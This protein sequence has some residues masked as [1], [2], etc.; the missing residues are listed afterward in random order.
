MKKNKRG[1]NQ[2]TWK[3]IEFK[4]S[5][6]GKYPQILK[7]WD[8]KKNKLNPELVYPNTNKKAH[9]I[10]KRTDNHKWIR[11]ICDESYSYHRFSK[12]GPTCPHCKIKNIKYEDS[13]EYN[14][15]VLSKEFDLKKN[16][17]LKPED[18]SLSSRLSLWWIC[19]R[20][21]LHKFKNSTGNRI[22]FSQN[23]PR[24]GGRQ[25][26]KFQIIVYT[27]LKSIFKKI[28]LADKSTNYELD[29]YEQDFNFAVEIDSLRY[30]QDKVSL[31]KKK[32]EFYRNQNINIFRIREKGLKKISVSDI[33]YKDPIIRHDEVYQKKLINNLLKNI[34]ETISSKNIK[35]KIQKYIIKK[36]LQNKK[37]FLKINDSIP[38]PLKGNSLKEKF[39][40]V[41]KE[42]H[43]T[44]NG[45]L[46]PDMISRASDNKVWWLCKKNKKH[47]W[48]QTPKHRTSNKAGCP[49]CSRQ[50]A[51]A[52]NNIKKLYPE[53][54]KQ[55]HIKLNKDLD[56]AKL[57]DGSKFDA[58]WICTENSKHVFKRQVRVYIKKTRKCPICNP[59]AG[60]YKSIF[61]IL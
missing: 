59:S 8:Y 42:F 21:N 43:P 7:F 29:I 25:L 60:T 40:E 52:D 48:K 13:L 47:I 16:F 5:L 35:T 38:G 17:P 34:K 15:P 22:R 32:N 24:C 19:K 41:A 27:E 51:D 10:C 54:A 56:V 9:W 55:F 12:L 57:L 33:E 26:S 45:S 39:P 3:K 37:E 6:A 30:H 31:D 58:W 4:D 1:V 18:I 53:V 11:R 50:F 44:K 28:K 23:C 61:K 20:N 46:K 49:Y 2:W 36:T 14:Y